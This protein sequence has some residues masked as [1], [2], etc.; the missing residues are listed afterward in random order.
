[1]NILNTISFI[2]L[3]SLAL[4]SSA[5]TEDRAPVIC[6][7]G[8]IEGGEICDGEALANNSCE[9]EGFIGGTLGCA[10]NCRSLVITGCDQCG[11]GELNEG[12]VCDSDIMPE[13]FSCE[14]MDYVGGQLLCEECRGIATTDCH[15]CGN[16]TVDPGEAC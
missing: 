5:C 13:G 15:N 8:I 16:L 6:G 3:F 11:N 4:L 12:E 7:N 9:S 1:M 2:A 10:T 14:E